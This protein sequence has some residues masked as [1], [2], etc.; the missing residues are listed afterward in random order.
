MI[1]EETLK[2]ARIVIVDDQEANGL[3]IE[4]LLETAG[5]S[6]FR[7]HQRPCQVRLMYGKFQPDLILLDLVMPHL[8]GY[9]GMQ[10]IGPRVP[11]RSILA[12]SRAYRLGEPASQMRSHPG[13]LR[14]TTGKRWL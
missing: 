6:N 11:G 8:D 5:G 7:Q 10:Q 1:K 9:S 3:L 12:D 2:N 13:R 14:L 4:Q